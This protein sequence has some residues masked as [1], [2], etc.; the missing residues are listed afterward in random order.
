MNSKSCRFDARV[1]TQNRQNVHNKFQGTVDLKRGF[2]QRLS[3]SLSHLVF[4]KWQ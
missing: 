4:D 2:L 3:Q 1:A